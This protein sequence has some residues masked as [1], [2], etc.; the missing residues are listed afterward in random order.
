MRPWT[1]VPPQEGRRF[2]ITGAN[3]GIG[4]HAARILG[5]R[6]AEV[7]LA[8]RNLDKGEAAARQVPGYDAGR[9][10]V[11]RLDVADL[12]SVREFAAGF[13]EDYDGLDVLVNNAGVLGAPYGLTEDG[14]E[15]HFA[16]NYLGHFAL[17]NLLLPVVR[18]RVVVI[19]SRE[20]RR[21]VVDLDDLAWEK[22][23]YRVFHA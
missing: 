16:T 10:S 15:T 18:D 17:T 23:T 19:S 12:G 3:S 8:C 20:H 11:R 13:L 5:S 21:G 9:V 4:F 14:F 2:V 6:G 1:A 22:R 7:V